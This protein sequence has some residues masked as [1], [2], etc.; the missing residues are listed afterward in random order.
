ML[1]IDEL[2]RASRDAIESLRL[3]KLVAAAGKRLV[4]ATDGFDS[5]QPQSKM[6]LHMFAM[7]HEWF[8]DQL[9]AKVK[10][11]MADGFDRGTTIGKPAFGYILVPDTDADGQPR[12]RPNGLPRHRR[13]IEPAAAELVVE[14]FRRFA[15]EGWSTTRLARWLNER[16]AGGRTGW[17]PAGVRKALDRELYA[18]VDWY[19]KSYRVADPET[20]RVEVRRRPE[21][22]WRRREAPDLR[23]VP[24]DLWDR[25][26]A[27][28]AVIKA[29]Y[30]PPAERPAV[31]RTDVYPTL[32]I[33][34]RCGHCDGNLVLIRSGRY[35]SLQCRAGA[36]RQHGCRLT[37]SK[38]VRILNA[39]VLGRLAPLI[40]DPDFVDRV[41]AAA[42][43][44]L[45]ELTAHPPSPDP[46]RAELVAATAR[47]RRLVGL[48]ERGVGDADELADR[49]RGLDARVRA[50]TDQL[51]GFTAA[52][53]P[54]TEPLTA[55]AAAALLADLPGLLAG[56][57]AA[58][59]PLLREL[60]GTVT[61]TQADDNPLS[62]RGG[63]VW[64]ARFTVD[65]TPALAYLGRK[66]NC[67]TADTWEYLKSSGWT[68][69]EGATVAVDYVPN[70]LR[71]AGEVVRGRA[72][73]ATYPD[74]AAG[75]G[76]PQHV[77]IDA[78]RYA[79]H[80][81]R[82]TAK[83]PGRR[84]GSGGPPA[85]LGVAAEVARLRDEDRLPFTRI[86]G[87]LGVSVQCV[88]RAY[89]HQHRDAIRAEVLAGRAPV[90]GRRVNIRPELY[91]R[92]AREA[93]PGRAGSRR[94]DRHRVLEEYRLPHP[95]QT[96]FP[97]RRPCLLAAST[98]AE[99]HTPRP[100]WGVSRWGVRSSRT[101][102]LMPDTPPR[103]AVCRPAAD[104]AGRFAVLLG[105]LIADHLV[106]LSPQGR[107]PRATEALHG[108][109]LAGRTPP[110]DTE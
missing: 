54:S 27:R 16:A 7:L 70:Y 44:R 4:G 87:R 1:Y 43:A 59:A 64:A 66:K 25:A 18:G 78:L 105:R 47:R 101:E 2:G 98:S 57:V 95:G 61:V 9:R 22:E 88:R 108:E 33:R 100:C 79:R 74:I 30:R 21:S 11:G 60:I 69:P 48:V 35:Q 46:V 36:G 40:A 49:I 86:A 80:G 76:I 51:A 28:Q 63:A 90:P 56:D 15:S 81:R 37:A 71:W 91:R 103:A 58:A 72:A 82:P 104:A 26:K 34:P 32:L 45:A 99:P 23:I 96:D 110:N 31:S 94:G 52:P 109:R 85:Y 68:T 53:P 84:T 65:A 89:S 6:M 75:L 41:V 97:Y 106:G 42:N 29:A 17:S 107:P 93:G 8:V 83:K 10:R 55:A 3:G 62:E 12:L 5:A 92:G 102:Q 20:G 13:V 39:A 19:G 24:P 67:P 38:S 50:L 14:L 73:G 77:V